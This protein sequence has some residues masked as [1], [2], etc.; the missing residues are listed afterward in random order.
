[1]LF[2]SY[3]RMQGEKFRTGFVTG[4][5]ARWSPVAVKRILV[6]ESYIGTLVQGKEEKINYKLKKSVMKPQEEWTRVP[7]AHEAVISRE[8]F[9]AACQVL[10]GA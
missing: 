6:N 4:A 10:C 3:K 5:R 9:K 1:M 7:E 2:R 8:D